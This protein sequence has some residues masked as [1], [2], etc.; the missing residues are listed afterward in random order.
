MIES[1]VVS[2]HIPLPLRRLV[3]GR[4]EVTASG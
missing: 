3:D 4:E 1:P 2:I